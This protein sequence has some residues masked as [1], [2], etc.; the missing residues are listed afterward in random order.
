VEQAA[1]RWQQRIKRARQ[2]GGKIPDVDMEV[3]YEEL[4]RDP[5]GQLREVCEFVELDFDPVMLR[6][7]E[8]AEERLGEIAKTL[9]AHGG[10]RELDAET[11]MEAHQMAVK[12]LSDERVGVWR[13]EMDPA[14][15]ATFEEVAGETLEEL[16]YP[17]RGS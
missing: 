7:H 10:A 4:V 12:P 2:I 1:K 5:E 11:R 9:P 8:G 17:L 6:H 14:D 16:G 13:Q 3:R 15:L